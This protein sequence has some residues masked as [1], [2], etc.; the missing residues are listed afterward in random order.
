MPKQSHSNF[1]ETNY[2]V[3]IQ[4]FDAKLFFMTCL[5]FDF[6]VLTCFFYYVGQ[7]NRES[8]NISTFAEKVQTYRNFAE[9]VETY[10]NLIETVETHQ[11]LADKVEI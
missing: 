1:F 6:F 3:I 9:K 8:R 5:C 4:L 7:D 2:V 10:R 11:F